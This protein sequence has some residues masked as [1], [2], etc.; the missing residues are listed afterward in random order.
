MRTRQKAKI[1]EL[2]DALLQA[3]VLTLD[4][5]AEALGLSRSTTWNLLKG[6]HKTSGLSAKIISRMLAAPRLPSSARA[7]VLKYV[8]EKTTGLYGDGKLR[9]DKFKAQLPPPSVLGLPLPRNQKAARLRIASTAWIL[10]ESFSV[11]RLHS[12]E[13]DDLAD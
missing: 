3:G 4:A 8:A 7:K 13:R 11:H 6:K 9:I 5:Q 1:T 12:R 2:K 10:V